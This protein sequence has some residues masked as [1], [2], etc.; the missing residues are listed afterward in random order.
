VPTTGAAGIPGCV[1]MTAL[2]DEGDVH[3]E[4]FVTVNVYVP[5]TNP[6]I[7]VLDPVPLI[8]PGF[9]VQVPVGNP[10]NAILPV[11]VEQVSCV[12]TPTT[13]AEGVCG[14]GLTTMLAEAAE[15]HP[16]ELVT[17]NE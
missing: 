2:A 12:I 15:V 9:M 17:V 11:T 10:D 14:C 5:G 1:L 7:V 4:A 8:A 13:G 16:T 6:V 3:P